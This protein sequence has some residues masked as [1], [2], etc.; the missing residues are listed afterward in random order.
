MRFGHGF[1][2]KWP[3][4]GLGM[5]TLVVGFSRKWPKS[6]LGHGYAGCRILSQMAENLV[7]AWIRWLSDSLAN[8]RNPGLGM[9]LRCLSDSLANGRKP[10]LGMDTQF[11]GF[12]RKW[13][14][15]GFGHGYAG[16]RILSQMSENLVWAWIRW[17]SDSL[18][19]GRKPGLGM[20]TQ[21]V[22]FS[23]KWPKSGFGHGS[24]LLVGFSRKW[25]KSGFG[26]G[27]TLLVGFSRKCPKTWFG[28]G[29][30]VCRILSQMAEIR[31]WAWVCCLSDSL[32][33]GR[34]PGLGMDTVVVGF[35]RKW[36]KSGF[37][38]GYTCWLSDSLANVRKPGFGMDTQFVQ[39]KWSR[40][41]AEPGAVFSNRG[42]FFC[43]SGQPP[44]HA[45]GGVWWGGVGWVG[46]PGLGMGMLVVGFSR[47]CPKTWFLSMDTVVVGFSRKWPKSGFGHGS[48]LLV[49]FSRKC[50]KTWFG[51][52]WIRSLSDSLANGRNPGFWAWVYAACR[53]LSQMAEIRAWAWV[54]WLSDSLANGRKPG[55]GM[56]TVVVGFSRKWPKTW[57]GHGYAACR[58]LSQMAENRVWAWIRWL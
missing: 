10:G 17:L 7:W 41:H 25:P 42:H 4:P 22:G 24:T 35:S 58:I 14:K 5:D 1:S 20:D 38:H 2:R 51:H 44:R 49:G 29:Y 47:K 54:C 45:A 36:P 23:R 56:D 31:V 34:K 40:L 15:S 53:I 12:S 16:C 13:P 19:N 39:K 9:G 57:F 52:A 26:H 50:P 8:G 30:A 6:G 27:S 37:G 32:A 3:K 18:A 33:N 43:A 46:Y 28:H 48:T 21:F 55:L 11:V